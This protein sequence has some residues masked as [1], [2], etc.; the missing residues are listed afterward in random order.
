[1]GYRRSGVA[2]FFGVVLL[3]SFILMT[4]LILY[5]QTLEWVIFR[6]GIYKEAL[7]QVH[8]YQRFPA[9]IE[10][11]FS[12]TMATL[13]PTGTGPT[14]TTN[15]LQYLKPQDYETIVVE[16]FPPD[17]LKT[18][19]EQIIDHL[20]TYINT[21][22]ATMSIDL[23]M[24]DVKNR[25]MGDQGRAIIQL[26]IQSWP[27][28]TLTQL[29]E[30]ATAEYVGNFQPLPVCRPTQAF[31]P[32][33]TPL[34]QSMIQNLATK[35]PDQID[36]TQDFDQGN[37]AGYPPPDLAPPGTT[38]PNFRLGTGYWIVRWVMRLSPI[39]V[40]VMLVLITVVCVRGP[41]S[42]FGWWGG[43]F[44]GAGFLAAASAWVISMLSQTLFQTLGQEIVGNLPVVLTEFLG[45]M[46]R[47][48]SIRALQWV[49]LEGAVM[50]MAG[51]VVFLISLFIRRNVP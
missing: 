46:A 2:L 10:D 11:T 42:L 35:L 45:E 37:L 15:Y 9:L 13:N 33:I 32:L 21:P 6:P 44:F 48:I 20:F 28:C 17:W 39:L 29:L 41:R 26:V 47:Y 7:T 51:L 30:L 14:E 24:I 38:G 3:I 40:L 25:L 18:Q 27:D 43:A 4:A 50:G 8:F 23:P 36:L 12:R 16:L 5:V 49:M 1:M 31:M 19:T 34:A 22:D